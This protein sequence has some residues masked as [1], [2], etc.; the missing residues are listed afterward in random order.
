VETTKPTGTGPNHGE[1]PRKR[2]AAEVGE[3][4]PPISIFKRAWRRHRRRER[5]GRE[6][7]AQPDGVRPGAGPLRGVPR[8]P[9]REPRRLRDIG[10]RRGAAA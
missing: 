10:G 3:G 4:S 2:N 8:P 5:R 9:D 7:P 1:G 6:R